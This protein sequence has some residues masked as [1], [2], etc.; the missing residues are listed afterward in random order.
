[1]AGR[2]Q[3][4]RGI[5]ATSHVDMSK[6]IHVMCVLPAFTLCLELS[7]QGIFTMEEGGEFVHS[8]NVMQTRQ[9]SLCL[10]VINS[11]SL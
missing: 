3:A 4:V 9:K 11:R 2:S 1:M 6:F 5:N 10:S 8:R 7:S